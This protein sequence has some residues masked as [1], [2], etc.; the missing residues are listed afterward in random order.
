MISVKI[1]TSFAQAALEALQRAMTDMTP[2]MDDIGD[3][4]ITSTKARF[5]QGVAPDGTKWAAKSASTL[6]RSRDPRPL[7]GPTGLLSQQIH[8]EAGLD[9]VSWGSSLIYAGV[10]QVGAAQ[11][12]FGTSKRGGP[13]PWGTIPA[14]P[15]IGVSAED[16]T[17]IL[18]TLDYWLAQ[19]AGNEPT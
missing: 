6:A 8:Y 7:F 3:D 5:A 14:R 18:S 11:G 17:D 10:M 16:E 1:N 19:A 4:L 15:F 12:A 9:G 2:A 13:L